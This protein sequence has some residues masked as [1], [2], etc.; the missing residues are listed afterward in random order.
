MVQVQYFG[1]GTMVL[2]FDTSKTKVLKLKVIKFWGINPMFLKLRGK[3]WYGELF[4]P[5]S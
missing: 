3:N 1:T 5:P 4:H 2:K